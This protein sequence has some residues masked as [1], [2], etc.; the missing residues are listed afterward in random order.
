MIVEHPVHFNF[1]RIPSIGGPIFKLCARVLIVGE[2]CLTGELFCTS[3]WAITA[4]RNFTDG[5]Q[6]ICLFVT[7]G[8][9]V[10]VVIRW[11]EFVSRDELLQ[12]LIR[13][14]DLVISILCSRTAGRWI[15][16]IEP[17]RWR[18]PAV[19]AK[20]AYAIPNGSTVCISIAVAFGIYNCIL[21][22]QFLQN[23]VVVRTK[24]FRRTA[25]AAIGPKKYTWVR[26]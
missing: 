10:P 19:S 4:V 2:L 24:G 9:K 15:F 6:L 7:S 21:P 1:V 11:P 3:G 22:V 14:N 17:V 25:I 16:G 5:L 8:M 20:H 13:R 12:A 18:M 23:P 26:T